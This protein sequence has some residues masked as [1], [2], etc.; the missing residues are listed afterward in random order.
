MWFSGGVR[1]VYRANGSC[2]DTQAIIIQ[3]RMIVVF[4]SGTLNQR[5]SLKKLRRTPIHAI[6]SPTCQQGL[7]QPLPPP[8][9]LACHV[10]AVGRE[11]REGE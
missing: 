7:L 6:A 10:A 8:P 1:S 9:S 5:A 2:S 4:S 11:G 3:R